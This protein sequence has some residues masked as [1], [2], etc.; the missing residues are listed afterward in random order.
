V[1]SLLSSDPCQGTSPLRIDAL[2]NRLDVASGP[3][4]ADKI[5]KM[6][7]SPERSRAKLQTRCSVS[8]SINR[9]LAQAVSSDMETPPRL[10]EATL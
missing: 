9:V 10:P 4:L 2:E 7:P 5:S 1:D 3:V 6:A 8:G